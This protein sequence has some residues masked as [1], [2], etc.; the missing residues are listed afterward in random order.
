MVLGISDDF[1]LSTSSVVFGASAQNGDMIPILIF[2]VDDT[3]VESLESLDLQISI[4]PTS[5]ISAT[6]DGSSTVAVTI[7]DSDSKEYW[8]CMCT[9]WD[10]MCYVLF[11]QKGSILY[12]IIR[13]VGM[14]RMS[15][16][17]NTKCSCL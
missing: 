13:I 8:R 16:I 4:S 10:C 9:Y 1:L 3:V 2:V 11:V 7:T 5:P 6:I 14:G 12:F 17:C 15:H